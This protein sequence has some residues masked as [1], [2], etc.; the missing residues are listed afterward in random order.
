MLGFLFEGDFGRPLDSVE[1]FERLFV[2]GVV[3]FW[4]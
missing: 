3:A 2:V 1:G 4:W